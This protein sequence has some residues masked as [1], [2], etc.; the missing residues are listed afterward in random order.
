MLAFVGVILLL[1]LVL[2]FLTKGFLFKYLR[3]KASQGRKL[4]IEV[5]AATDDYYAVGK[6]EDGFL[7]FK[8]R[9]KEEKA[10]EMSSSA[11]RDIITRIMGVSKI[12]VD[13]LGNTFLKKD[14]EAVRFEV[15]SGR[16]NTT[17]IR[18][19]NRPIPKSKQEQLIIIMLVLVILGL[20]GLFLKINTLS[21]AITS[22]TSL[23][24]VV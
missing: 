16:L 4:L 22:I 11:F 21:D 18:I 10:I 9:G 3:V 12:N 6:W 8:N 7:K 1:F 15:D 14:F 20:I 24:G 2:N 23:A 19:K 5:S 17:L 13:E